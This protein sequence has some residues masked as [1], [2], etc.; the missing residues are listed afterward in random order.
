MR[1]LS[2]GRYRDRVQAFQVARTPTSTGHST[3]DGN[4]VE[5]PCAISLVR[6]DSVKRYQSM[7][8][9]FIH[10]LRFRSPVQDSDGDEVTIQ[11]GMTE[12]TWGE[13]R[14]IPVGPPYSPGD[15]RQRE[16]M[17]DCRDATQDKSG[18]GS[19]S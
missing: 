10:R 8:I 13:K 3:V 11:Y 9:D 6:A 16:M 14:L 5:L 2:A 15:T 4:A 19:G 1:G 17:V 18:T 7:D 12:F